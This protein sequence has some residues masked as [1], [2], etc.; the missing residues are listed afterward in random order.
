MKFQDPVVKSIIDLTKSFVKHL[1][2][3][4]VPYFFGYKAEFF[5][6]KTI[7]KDLDPSNKTDLDLLD[8]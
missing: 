4:L 8:F 2:S 5:P 3:L 1:L 6:S 7:P